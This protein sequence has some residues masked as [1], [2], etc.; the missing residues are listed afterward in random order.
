M[1]QSTRGVKVFQIALMV[2]LF[3]A[4]AFSFQDATELGPMARE[5]IER[6]RASIVTIKAV[7]QSNET[8]SQALGFFIRKDLVATDSEIINKNSRLTAA[9]KDHPIKVVSSGNY[10]LPYV[11]LETQP[12]AVPLSLGESERVEVH[13]SVYMLGDAGEIVAGK[14]T[15]TTT[16]KHEAVF[17]VNLPI[18]SNNKGAPIF[19]RQGE[20]IG[21]AAKSSDG[22]NAAFAWPSHLLAT[23]KHLGEPGVGIG[24]GEGPRFP[25]QPA[26][27]N[28]EGS[29]TPSVDTRPVR[30]SS[31]A[32]KYTE[33]ARA[34][35]TQGLV[36]L[37]VRVG[38]D[39]I[40]NAIRVVR[41]LPDGL[42][43][44]AIAV[45]RETKFKPAMKDGNPVE[46]WLA[47]EIN[48]ILR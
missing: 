36:I 20:V 4:T 25:R 26:A 48:F 10:F 5:R 43:E 39:G 24:A 37:R 22:E 21:I 31:P 2:A 30:L 44:Q 16:L 32:P 47:L 29:T 42:T 9:I 45:A 40:V 11:L 46:F 12:D 27:P 1:D 28:L 8:I 17:L 7:D 38:V 3:A 41:G 23:L 14:V 6:A 19:N 15:G 13:D 33:A 18:N 34:N 35:N